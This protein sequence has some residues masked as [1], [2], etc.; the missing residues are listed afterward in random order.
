MNSQAWF[1]VLLATSRRPELVRRTLDSLS[2]CYL[3]RRFGGVWVIEN[4]QKTGAEGILSSCPPELRCQ[5]RFDPIANK[6]IALNLALR[7]IQNGFIFFTDDDVR[8]H[9]DVLRAYESAAGD[10]ASGSFYGGAVDIDYETEPP[11][12]LTEYLPS[13]AVGW[14]PDYGFGNISKADFLGC[15]WAAFAAD[16]LAAGG[17]NPDRGPGS[18]S[19]SVG[20]EKDMQ[21]RLLRTGARAVYIPNALVWHYVPAVNCSPQ[22]ALRR[23][24][25]NGIM[26]GL[27]YEGRLPKLGIY[28]LWALREWIGKVL[29][30]LRAWVLA[31]GL[32]RFSARYA[33][34]K[35]TGLLRGL[36]ASRKCS[37]SSGTE[38][39]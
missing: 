7:E 31:D 24:Y 8:F 11:R 26:N 9:P 19:G 22:W 25:R 5:Y 4:G 14:K 38:K 13:S 12:W 35:M 15:N 20:Q 6:S 33:L 1:F 36:R 29:S 21:R 32:A 37:V 34:F 39:Q 10:L 27:D 16:I 18:R 28:P 17:F 3:P 23:A 30:L 2:R